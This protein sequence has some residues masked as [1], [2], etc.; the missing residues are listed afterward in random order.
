MKILRRTQ[1][2]NPVLR[3]K[4]RELSNAEIL[5]DDIQKLIRDMKHTLKTKKYG[6]GLAATQVGRDVAVAV[7]EIKP[8]KLR[9]DLPKSEWIDRAIINPKIVKTYG[10]RTQRWE[11]CIS[12]SGV[13][14]KVPRYKKIRVSYVD[15]A[16]KQHE[17]DFS[18]LQ[19]HV[20]QH[21]IDHLSGVLFVD[22]V[23]DTATYMSEV[24]YIKLVKKASRK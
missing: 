23:K 11:G 10:N 20:L 7:I 12:L 16:G 18:G 8:T 14:A 4:T 6:I 9:P 2:G 13:F 5:S 1:F 3:Q 19:A 24:E 17:K 15:A 22:K 21:E